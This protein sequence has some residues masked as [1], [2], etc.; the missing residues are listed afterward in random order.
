MRITKI[1]IQGFKSFLDRETM[2]VSPGINVI[3]GPNGSGKSNLID[4]FNW[5]LGEQSIKALRGE[6]SEDVIFAGTSCRKPVGMAQ[7]SIFID[8]SDGFLP[9]DYSEIMITRR[10]YRSGE[11]QFFINKV[12][13]R[14][15][16]IRE[17]FMGTGS[18]KPAVTVI[19]QGQVDRV[20]SAKPQQRR[21]ILEEASGIS[22]Y[23]VKLRETR[24][25]LEEVKN[26][27]EK[28]QSFFENMEKSMGY[29]KMEAE[30]AFKYMAI[31]EKL[32][33]INAAAV[34]WE[35]KKILIEICRCS[36]EKEA[37]YLAKEKY[38]MQRDIFEK[39]LFRNRD[40]KDRVAHLG[41]KITNRLNAIG[42]NKEKLVIRLEDLERKMK[43]L[44][45]RYTRISNNMESLRA[46]INNAG[47]KAKIMEKE[48]ITAQK[49]IKDLKIKIEEYD[50][51]IQNFN[52][53]IDR[54]EDKINR[55][56][57]GI[58]TVLERAAKIK[59]E[60]T[61]EERELQSLKNERQRN[62]NRL[63]YL[64]GEIENLR[65]KINPIM[66]T[67]ENLTNK[68]KHLERVEDTSYKEIDIIDKRIKEIDEVLKKTEYELQQVI[69]RRTMLEKMVKNYEGY[70]KEIFLLLNSGEDFLKGFY[71]AVGELLKVPLPY[72]EA[73]EVC[74]GSRINNVV[75]EKAEDAK[76]AIKFL[77][78]KDAGRVTFLPL[79]TIVGTR[80]PSKIIDN[81]PLEALI[82][83]DV[84]E[85]KEE[86]KPAVEYLL[87]RIL[88]V[89]NL[90][91]ALEVAK[92]VKYRYTIVTKSGD[93]VHPGGA[94]TGGGRRKNKNTPGIL[95]R[96]EA[97]YDY[98]EKERALIEK[99]GKLAKEKKELEHGYNEEK[100][101]YQR[102]AS[103]LEKINTR[104]K[105]EQI[106]LEYI[107]NQIKTMEREK[108][109]LVKETEQIDASMGELEN[110][111]KLL[112][113]K[114]KKKEEAVDKLKERLKRYEQEV[115][116]LKEKRE[117]HL[118]LL[119][120]YRNDLSEAEGRKLSIEKELFILKSFKGRKE[121]DF[122][123]KKEELEDLIRQKNTLER[124]ILNLKWE[125]DGYKAKEKILEKRLDSVNTRLDYLS[126]RESR[127]CTVIAKIN[128]K[129]ERLLHLERKLEN[130]LASLELAFENLKE[131]INCADQRLLEG[132][133]RGI[134]GVNKKTFELQQ[135]LKNRLLSLEP[136]NLS[137]MD[138]Y[139]KYLLEREQIKLQLDDL[140]Q[141]YGHLK[142]MEK[143]LT[144]KIE[145]IYVDFFERIRRRF[146]E[147]YCNLFG[148][149]TAELTI[150]NNGGEPLNSGIEITVSPPGKKTKTLSL[151]SGGERALTALAFLFA[152][153]KERKSPFCILDEVDTSLD[154]TNV[155]RFARYLMEYSSMTQFII[156][157]H[158]QGT[159]EIADNLYGV[160]MPEHGVSKIVSVKLRNVG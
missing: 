69:S 158:R 43:E 10:L 122:Y 21:E 91:E 99:I 90:N 137:S 45:N 47:E 92:A 104:L 31:K 35:A 111:I 29:L 38:V 27:N 114:P 34:A 57:S 129:V 144:K 1:E 100:D 103:E 159:M 130:R 126:Q 7:V 116:R 96:R 153:L 117:N 78:E 105:E 102:A 151:L 84:V 5:V 66:Q 94:M 17:L 62:I 65:K 48:K 149:G 152:I 98:L 83:A 121:E 24:A 112:A 70:K 56:H 52:G 135:E 28:L 11:S 22:K 125:I 140:S 93:V 85:A 82:A 51:E 109:L 33:N 113:I 75:V 134:T 80:I 148:G 54:Y 30:K 46:E 49:K 88:L 132:Y 147:V 58:V 108:Q 89:N 39:L 12:P 19:N 55:I 133:F 4:A 18:G 157:S 53:E 138:E 8:N 74:L 101:K 87:G 60:L 6:K 120:S 95:G 128:K 106:S 3:V 115:F 68:K 143:V 123:Q 110:K 44:N 23:L 146:N 150:M 131:K 9:L 20:L 42:L 40:N 16:D 14:L 61:A 63:S 72:R 37:A 32:D 118:S 155:Q 67:V 71:G 2:E 107:R 41:E 25:F 13:C 124:D 139:K 136:V 50:S 97:V 36:R 86:L 76:K 119:N 77:K 26:N 154:E 142:Y 64:D 73:V 156:V 127:Y 81:L 15:R 141:A 160:T 145:R 59:N 79:D